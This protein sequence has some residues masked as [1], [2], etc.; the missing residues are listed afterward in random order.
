MTLI[1][2]WKDH[3]RVKRRPRLLADRHTARRQRR[4]VCS[5]GAAHLDG[6]ARNTLP[7][8]VM[9]PPRLPPRCS[10]SG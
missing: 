2:L 10:E 1:F 6:P 3:L 8:L 4:C 9:A 5:G 7:W